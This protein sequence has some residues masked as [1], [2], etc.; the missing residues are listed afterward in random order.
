MGLVTLTQFLRPDGARTDVSVELPDDIC[1]LAEKQVLSCEA[2][3][4]DVVAFY[5]YPVDRDPEETEI[6]SLAINGPGPD[7]PVETLIKLIKEV[8][9]RFK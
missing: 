6:T 7:S 2:L 8:A 9:E 5:S 4:E 3:N 1:K